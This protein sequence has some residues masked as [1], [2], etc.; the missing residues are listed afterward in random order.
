[1]FNIK[2]VFKTRNVFLLFRK[3][4][5]GEDYNLCN[6]LRNISVQGNNM[7]QLSIYSLHHVVLTKFYPHMKTCFAIIINAD[8]VF[9]AY[10]CLKKLEYIILLI[11]K[12]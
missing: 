7:L 3:Q 1:M 9:V 5:C 12:L 2:D 6:S 8:Q 4:C 11:T 10:N